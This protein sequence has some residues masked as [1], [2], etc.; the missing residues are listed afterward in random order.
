MSRCINCSAELPEGSRFC[1]FCGQPADFQN[2]TFTSDPHAPLN[3]S[4]ARLASRDNPSA[5]RPLNLSP[6]TVFADRYRIL[7][8]LGRGGMGM[9][10]KADDLNLG[11]VV[12]LKFLPASFSQSIGRIERF[13]AEVRLASPGAAFSVGHGRIHSS[14]A[15]FSSAFSLAPPWP[16]SLSSAPFCPTGLTST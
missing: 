12:A 8:L 4:P 11:Q 2:S 15:T 6:G 16:S 3:P 9:V 14:V 13:H 5:I 10:Y 1:S 7:G